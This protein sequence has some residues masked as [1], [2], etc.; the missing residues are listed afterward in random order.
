MVTSEILDAKRMRLVCGLR[1]ID[2]WSGTGII[3]GRLSKAENGQIRLDET[4]MVALVN[5]LQQ[6]WSIRRE[7]ERA[8]FD[9][10]RAVAMFD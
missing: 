9:S 6:Q 5:F 2:V 10:E 1:Q 4:E 8:V 3:P 7:S